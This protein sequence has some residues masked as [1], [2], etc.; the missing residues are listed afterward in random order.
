MAPVQGT[1]LKLERT[2][3]KLQHIF[4]HPCCL[5]AS[6]FG[7]P[8]LPRSQ[9]NPNWSWPL[10]APAP[11]LAPEKCK[12]CKCSFCKKSCCSCCSMDCAKCAQDLLCKG[13]SDSAAV[14]LDVRTVLLP[15]V[16]AYNSD[17]FAIFSCEVYE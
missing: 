2:L 11:V 17:P 12:K 13:A 8:A 14:V 16:F 6:C 4:Q 9:M 15:D 1:S 10:V 3:R 5:L 7:T